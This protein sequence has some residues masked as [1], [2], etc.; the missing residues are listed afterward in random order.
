M[1]DKS[2]T[3]LLLG[4]KA[5]GKTS[6]CKRIK[7]GDFNAEYVPS[8][9]TTTYCNTLFTNK[10]KATV[11]ITDTAY[12]NINRPIL[13]SNVDA[14]IIMF[15]LDKLSSFKSVMKWY[16]LAKKQYSDTVPIILVGNKCDRLD[17]Q[18]T[19]DMIQTAIY[20]LDIYYIDLSVKT[21]FNIEKPQLTL[22]RLIFKV[23]DLQLADVIVP[24]VKV[25]ISRKQEIF[26]QLQLLLDELKTIKE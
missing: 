21:M 5:V 1:T 24:L 16:T 10:G 19:K 15:S 4:D 17:H 26:S 18:V 14:V 6:F 8:N 2:C 22:A 7:T 13:P 23:P 25:I 11:D 12:G 20:M 9:H 3:L